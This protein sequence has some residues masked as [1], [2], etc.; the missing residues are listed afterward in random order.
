M[1]KKHSNINFESVNL[2]L[3]DNLA[4]ILSVTGKVLDRLL[5]KNLSE[6]FQW[7]SLTE[8]SAHW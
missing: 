5:Q 3:Y 2:F 4:A 8:N 7:N 6:L 1:T